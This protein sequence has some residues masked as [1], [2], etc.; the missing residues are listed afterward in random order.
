MNMHSPHTFTSRCLTSFYKLGRPRDNQAHISA[1]IGVHNLVPHVPLQL[2]MD[3]PE[4]PPVLPV[5][6]PTGAS[7]MGVY[8]QPQMQAI[9]ATHIF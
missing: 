8:R 2:P 4:E 9:Y 5:R 1:S 3:A 6:P 7:L